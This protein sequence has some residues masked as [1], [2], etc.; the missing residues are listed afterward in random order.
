LKEREGNG[1]EK[2]TGQASK[3]CRKQKEK[4][5]RGQAA[6]WEQKE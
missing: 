2:E 6:N 3:K 4:A 1:R 5:E